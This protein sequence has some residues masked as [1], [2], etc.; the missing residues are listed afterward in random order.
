MEILQPVQKRLERNTNLFWVKKFSNEFTNELKTGF[1]QGVG[2]GEE[3]QLNL[4][5]TEFMFL[6]RDKNY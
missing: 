5:R 2:G 4:Q 1:F 3:N 6:F